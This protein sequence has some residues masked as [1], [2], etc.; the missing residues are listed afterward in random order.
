MTSNSEAEFE[1]RPAAGRHCRVRVP[2][3]ELDGSISFALEA[4]TIA[5]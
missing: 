1:F 4:L 2:T 5:E 3:Y